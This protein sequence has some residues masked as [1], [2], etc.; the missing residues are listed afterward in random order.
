MVKEQSLFQARVKGDHQV[1][2]FRF[3][4]RQCFLPAKK[5]SLF[6]FSSSLIEP[7]FS[8]EIGSKQA[9]ISELCQE[10]LQNPQDTSQPNPQTWPQTLKSSNFPSK[11]LTL[12]IVMLPKCLQGINADVDVAR[13]GGLLGFCVNIDFCVVRPLLW[14]LRERTQHAASHYLGSRHAVRG[15]P[16]RPFKPSIKV[17]DER[18]GWHRH[19]A[20]LLASYSM[21]LWPR[22]CQG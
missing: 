1:F 5:I 20:C 12:V 6:C 3:S 7:M 9:K 14:G 15:P 2:F 18:F 16:K 8:V 11:N 22:D 13:L 4:Q 21:E 10:K 17:S 19:R